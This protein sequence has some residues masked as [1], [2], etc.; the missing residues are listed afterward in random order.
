MP[1]CL[2]CSNTRQPAKITC[3]KIAMK[4]LSAPSYS[5]KL[6]QYRAVVRAMCNLTQGDVAIALSVQSR[7]QKST[8]HSHVA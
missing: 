5:A 4:R 7:I 1:G 2:I 6:V 8:F 3:G